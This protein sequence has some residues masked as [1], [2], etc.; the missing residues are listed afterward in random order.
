MRGIAFVIVFAAVFMFFFIMSVGIW[1]YRDAKKK[2]LPAVMWAVAA[3]LLPGLVGLLI[4]IV[5]RADKKPTMKCRSCEKDIE[6]GVGFCPYCGYQSPPPDKPF[7][8]AKPSKWLT[9]TIFAQFTLMFFIVIAVISR[10]AA[11]RSY[12]TPVATSASVPTDYVW[13][14]V[15]YYPN[16]TASYPDAVPSVEPYVRAPYVISELEMEKFREE[17]LKI[18]EELEN[19]IGPSPDDELSYY[20]RVNKTIES[21]N[22]GKYYFS[23]AGRFPEDNLWL[24]YRMP[25]NTKEITIRYEYIGN[26]AFSMHPIP[27]L[28]PKSSATIRDDDGKNIG[29]FTY[30][31]DVFYDMGYDSINLY[32]NS[33]QG[34]PF[35]NV[36]IDVTAEF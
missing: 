26:A 7:K 11:Q 13:E 17:Q 30:S 25:N 10:L 32:I 3:T 19:S 29:S 20:T 27:E 12:N 9:V 16:E 23:S 5:Y 18:Q 31:A 1:V 4:Y 36:R 24:T 21:Y 8:A 28:S 2:G 34:E 6:W 22:N 15:T 33:N 35:Y 14:E